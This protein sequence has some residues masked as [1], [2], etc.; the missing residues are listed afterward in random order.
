MISD[1]MPF[2]IAFSEPTV[3]DSS[4]KVEKVFEGLKFPTSM[5]FL[6]EGDIIAL[7][8]NEGKVMRIYNGSLQQEPLLDLDVAT[9]GE[10]GMLGLALSENKS[11]NTTYVFLFFTQASG[12]EGKDICPNDVD[13]FPYC[14]SEND[15]LGNMVYR[16]QLDEKKRLVNPKLML[17]LPAS[18]NRH[19]GGQLLIGPDGNLYAL[20]GDLNRST[21]A[22]NYLNGTEPDGTSGIL[23]ITQDGEPVPNGSI[24]GEQYPL[25][26]Y[27]AYGIRNSFGMDFDPLTG[28]LWDTEN[29]LLYGDEINLVEPGFNSGWSR[30][31][32]VW[33]SKQVGNESRDLYWKSIPL[34]SKDVMAEDPGNLVTFNGQGNYSQPEFTWGFSVAPTAL[35]FLNSDKLGRQYEN[36]MFV[37]DFKYG[38]LYHFDLNRNRTQLSLNGS[39][40]HKIANN[41]ETL[42]STLFGQGFGAITDLEV[43]PDGNL[44]VLSLYKG[45]RDCRL[46]PEDCVPYNSAIGGTIFRISQPQ[47]PVS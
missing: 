37:G 1:P 12:I 30:V 43:G 21:R 47:N 13:I 23:R 32:G 2:I 14:S 18:P 33:E 4:L 40:A 20:I 3:K 19:N 41:V 29:G 16:Y 24:I 34:R 22:Q 9:Q 44:Y 10:R 39:L 35:K 31:Q 15:P 42:N 27:Y 17:D 46:T 25:N 38:N 5:A 8:K 45:G 7:E 26:L 28:N 36:D 6:K 11:E